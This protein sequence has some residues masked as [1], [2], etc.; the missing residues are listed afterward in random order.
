MRAR[1]GV[2]GFTTLLAIS[3]AVAACVDEVEEASFRVESVAIRDI[4]VSAVA[5][6]VVEPVITVEVKS[7][8]SGEI[9]EVL[10]EEGD[11]VRAGQLLARVDPRIPGNAVMQAEADSVVAR[12]ELDN[13]EAQFRRS[14]ALFQSQ[15]IT[16]QEFEAARLA[17]AAAYASLIRARRAL[18]DA[19]IAF[20]DTEVR[21]ASDGVI[22]G[23]TV[24]VGTVIAAASRDVGG[25]AVLMR[26]AS[27]D[28]IQV[29]ALVDETDIGMV[30]GGLDVSI[31]VEAYPARVF[32]GKV[33]RIGPEALV[34]QNV[35]LFPVIIQIDNRERLLRPGMNA[36]V[37]I[38]IGAIE[39]AIAVPNAA[40]RE[41]S[42]VYAA[43]SML[44]LDAE[45]VR[46]QLGTNAFVIDADFG[47]DR[48]SA[49]GASDGPPAREDRMSAS[50]F[51]GRYVVFVL[52]DGEPVAV[53]IE[54]GLT[55]FDFTA[56]T[57]GLD[58]AEQVIILPTAGIVAEQQ[59]RQESIQRRVGDPLSNRGPR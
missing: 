51:G 40:L 37:E 53:A 17:R 20:E 1:S 3:F 44:G 52:R 57:S 28:T 7:K 56:V 27:L 59:R 34:Q 29:R 23:R 15:S 9:I 21:A 25:G 47:Y 13:A 18:E 48:S 32:R 12:A 42:D 54:T 35:T 10:V 33:L 22:L 39:D 8:A 55:D 50:L 16:E 58:G 4:V 11:E 30:R 24:E 26:M 6:G 41:P 14:E 46:Q 19:K 2:A 5:A 43:A 36:E 49:E 45:Q 31:V 38:H